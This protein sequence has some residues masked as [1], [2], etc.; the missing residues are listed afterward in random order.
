[1]FGHFS[2]NKHCLKTIRCLPSAV[3]SIT[4]ICYY[5]SAEDGIWTHWAVV[6][7][8][9]RCVFSSRRLHMQQLTMHCWLIWYVY[10]PTQHKVTHF[11]DVLPCQSECAVYRTSELNLRCFGIPL[12]HSRSVHCMIIAFAS[13]G[14]ALSLV[15]DCPVFWNYHIQS[16]WSQRGCPLFISTECI[17][18]HLKCSIT[19]LLLLF[20][21]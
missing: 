8:T 17:I 15:T 5:F 21:L 10:H 7:W 14:A 2:F 13:V 16:F 19:R 11:G 18:L 6:Q 1:M 20:C 12:Q 3:K 9:G 4:T